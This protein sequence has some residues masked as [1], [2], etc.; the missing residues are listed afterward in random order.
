MERDASRLCGPKKRIQS[1]SSPILS[2]AQALKDII[3]PNFNLPAKSQS[4]LPSSG[5]GSTLPHCENLRHE[6]KFNCAPPN[7]I[8]DLT[9]KIK[10]IKGAFSPDEPEQP[11]NH[12]QTAINGEQ[13]PANN[14]HTPTGKGVD[15]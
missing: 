7:A 3:R 12:R 8:S 14:R 6:F 9:W 4:L 1:D 11:R 10:I 15:R 2:G 13:Q 5:E